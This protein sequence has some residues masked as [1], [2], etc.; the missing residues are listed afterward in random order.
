MR[1]KPAHLL[2]DAL[3]RPAAVRSESQPAA[4]TASS[5]RRRRATARLPKLGHAQE[6]E[7]ISRQRVHLVQCGMAFR[8]M[9]CGVA[10]R[11]MACGVAWGVRGMVCCTARTWHTHG[12]V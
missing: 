9:A 6:S 1:L 8:G 5:C 10:F 11:G 7:P 2:R 3:A 12:A 4:T